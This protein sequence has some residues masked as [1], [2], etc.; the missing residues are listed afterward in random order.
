MGV[1]PPSLACARKK[2]PRLKVPAQSVGL[3]GKQSGIY[4]VEAPGGWQ[5]IG[6]TPLSIFDPLLTEPMRLR[7]G[8][9]ISFQAIT[10]AEY[11]FIAE[12]VRNQTYKWQVR[13]YR[14]S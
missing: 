7:P 10:P 4:P 8:D 12:Q 5:I 1:S 6:K 11:D 3:A 9:Q 2:K 14:S 13:E